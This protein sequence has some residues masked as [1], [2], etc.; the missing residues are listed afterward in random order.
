M[1]EDDD[2]FYSASRAGAH[3]QVRASRLAFAPIYDWLDE[4]LAGNSPCD[5]SRMVAPLLR[6][7]FSGAM[8]MA[9]TAG[10]GARVGMAV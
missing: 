6:V 5:R 10:V 2:R 3:C 8:A 9:V 7:G 4:T 1:S